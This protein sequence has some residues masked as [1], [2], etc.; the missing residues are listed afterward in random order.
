LTQTPDK[1]NQSPKAKAKNLPETSSK[2]LQRKRFV[3]TDGKHVWGKQ[4]R[5]Q[6]IKKSREK[7]VAE[8]KLD[9]TKMKIAIQFPSVQQKLMVQEMIRKGRDHMRSGPTLGPQTSLASPLPLYAIFIGK[10]SS[11]RKRLSH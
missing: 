5:S 2:N 1:R 3:D 11:T 4:K 7:K 10:Y 6:A 8:R 9:L